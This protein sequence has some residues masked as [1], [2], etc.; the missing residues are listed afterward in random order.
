[1]HPATTAPVDSK[2]PDAELA[3]RVVA[4]DREAFRVLVKRYNQTLY[5]AARSVLRNE[6]EAE[7]AVQDAY[8][9]AYRAMGKFR[10]D[11]KLSTWLVRIVVN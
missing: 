8:L 4:G 6:A 9:L 11:A 1:M 2:L 7:D 10:G 5:R 3:K